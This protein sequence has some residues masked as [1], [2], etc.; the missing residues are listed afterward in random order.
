MK[1]MRREIAES[2]QGMLPD[3]NP[4]VRVLYHIS[5][6]LSTLLFIALAIAVL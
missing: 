5:L 6:T 1:Q 2:V 4:A 3:L